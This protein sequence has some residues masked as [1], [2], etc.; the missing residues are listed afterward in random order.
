MS[1]LHKDVQDGEPKSSVAYEE[2]DDDE[3]EDAG[4]QMS[5]A[6]TLEGVLGI[7]SRG[8]FWAFLGG[9]A[10]FLCS[11]SHSSSVNTNRGSCLLQQRT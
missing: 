9:G 6:G 7:G 10:F 11:S 4:E 1:V 5:G 3:D 8:L 2:E